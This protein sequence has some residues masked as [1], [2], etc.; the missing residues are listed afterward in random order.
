[1]IVSWLLLNL[2]E[3]IKKSVWCSLV[4][5]SWLL[6][7]LLEEIKKSVWCSRVIFWIVLGQLSHSLSLSS[8]NVCESKGKN[9][10]WCLGLVLEFDVV[11]CYV[12]CRPPV[13]RQVLGG[14]LSPGVVERLSLH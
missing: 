9:P 8:L 6:F 3:E 1:V 10:H 4:T 13:H 2:L 11:C 12:V 14:D 7:N 5:F